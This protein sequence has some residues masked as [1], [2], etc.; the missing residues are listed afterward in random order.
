MGQRSNYKT[1]QRDILLDYLES[2][3]N[4]HITAGDVCEHFKSCG[5]STGQATVYR[6]L[7]KLV[8]E[9]L[10]TK[11][12]IDTNSPACFEYTGADSHAHGD[13]CYHLKCE[14]CGRLIHLSCDEMGC[15]GSHLLTEHG[16]KLD[17]RRTVFYGL[18]SECM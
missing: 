4:T 10:A 3:K 18:C 13:A 11:Y 16:F 14:K 7:E 15:T 6:R 12:I 8:D 2:V 17:P 9:G 1:S 5:A